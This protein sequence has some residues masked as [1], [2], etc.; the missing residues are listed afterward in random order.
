M[1][2]EKISLPKPGA[3]LSTRIAGQFA[4]VT[5]YRQC[6]ALLASD[7]WYNELSVWSL[8]A[9]GSYARIEYMEAVATNPARAALRHHEIVE[10]L[11]EGRELVDVDSEAGAA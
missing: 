9:D 1:S 2:A 3:W 10:R 6:S 7:H 5:E 8:N 4:V 11:I